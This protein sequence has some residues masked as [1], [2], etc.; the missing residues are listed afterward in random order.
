ML[1]LKSLDNLKVYEIELAE[2]SSNYGQVYKPNWKEK[3]KSGKYNAQL[4]FML[5]PYNIKQPIVYR[6][7]YY[8]K[9][10]DWGIN[11]YFNSRSS[12]GHEERKQ[13]PIYNTFW[14][15]MNKAKESGNAQLERIAKT[16]LNWIQEWSSYVYIVNDFCDETW[17]DQFLIYSYKKGI[18]DVIQKELKGDE[19]KKKEPINIFHPITGKDFFL[20]MELKEF[21][22]YGKRVKAPSYNNSEFAPK[23][24]PLNVNGLEMDFD[25]EKCVEIFQKRF[26]SEG[27]IPDIR[28]FAYSENSA[29]DEHKLRKYLKYL[30]D[31]A[32]GGKTSVVVNSEVET[33]SE[34]APIQDKKESQK[35][36]V[37]T[38]SSETED[39][40]L[41]SYIDQIV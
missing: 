7:R 3:S 4:R 33:D 37:E 19:M 26:N 23:Q 25:N 18:H 30:Q 13:C 32:R 38:V 9:D 40:D 28:Q 35:V 17:N 31:M 6:V 27:E 41:D 24:S 10:E 1:D 20:E 29:E 22:S 11:G 21:D 14:M 12:L 39:E 8:I 36:S 15:L 2:V 34:S 16:R 5:N